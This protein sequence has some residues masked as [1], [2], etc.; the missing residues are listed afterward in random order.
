MTASAPSWRLRRARLDESN[1]VAALYRRVADAEWPFMAPHTPAED[2]VFFRDRIF[3]RCNVWVARDR[4]TIIGFCA[5]RRSWID[6]LHVE[7]VRHGEG[8]GSALLTRAL[9]G[10]RR[11][12]LW[13][14]Q[15]NA[16]SRRFYA[17]HG[18][19]EVRFT[20]GAENEERE[21][22]VLLKWRR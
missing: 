6:H 20:D 19:K 13:T 21:P 12:R 17:H 2:R 8:V 9:R 4:E 7:R 1:E 15:V 10:R 22:D 14:F 5:V 16:R 11:V 18:F 3:G